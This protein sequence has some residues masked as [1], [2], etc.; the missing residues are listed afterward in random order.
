MLVTSIADLGAYIRQERREQRLT[1]SELA[2]LS[3]VGLTFISQ[4]E[5]G[6]ATAEVGKV[7]NVLS[8]LGSDLIVERRR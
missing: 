3:G 8:V 7:L 2:G 1:Q 5:N 4:L 6:K